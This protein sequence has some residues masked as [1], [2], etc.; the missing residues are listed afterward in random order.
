MEPNNDLPLA[1]QADDERTPL[2]IERR[3]RI[4][5]LVNTRGTISVEELTDLLGTSST[6]VRRDL[7]WLNKQG[8]LTRTRGGAV[9]ARRMEQL[10]RTDPAYERRLGE[11]VEEK[12]AIGRLAADLVNDGE[13]IIIDSGSTA[14][15]MVPFLAGKRDLLVITPSQAV[16]NDF[17]PFANAGIRVVA[18][19]GTFR[20]QSR[21]FV[22]MLTEHALA[23]HFVEKAFLGVRGVSVEHGL[24]SPATE[25]IP[26]KR[27]IIKAA[28]QTIVLA[29]H[30]KLG[31]T[32]AGLI[33]PLSAAHMVITDE[34]AAQTHVQQIASK[35][36]RVLIARC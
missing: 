20:V 13:A 14:Q 12:Q 6:T 25:D 3:M 7:G 30:T 28:K 35:G 18:T 17:V 22:G 19:G 5:N 21:S 4:L 15:A 10:L 24:T 31:L 33:A 26:V 27:Q 1:L 29:D 8:L 32:Y 36:P 16:V 34:H 23:Q 9:G 2:V 11:N